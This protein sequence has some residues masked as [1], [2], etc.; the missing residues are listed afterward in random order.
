[1]SPAVRS[2]H[3]K[4]V[5]ALPSTSG[6]SRMSHPSLERNRS[7]MSCR[8][9]V[10]LARHQVSEEQPSSMKHTFLELPCSR[11][12]AFKAP[13]CVFQG[14]FKD[15][16]CMH[17]GLSLHAFWP[18]FGSVARG[19]W[20]EGQEQPGVVSGVRRQPGKRLELHQ[21][22]ALSLRFSNLLCS[23]FSHC[24]SESL[25]WSGA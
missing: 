19:G 22:V 15:F 7:L 24:R 18:K 5:P 14:I 4:Q 12:T 3:P 17:S 25:S 6:S 13:S 21:G 1:M 20:G 10:I 11:G 16:R 8:F 9:T 23:S 2:R